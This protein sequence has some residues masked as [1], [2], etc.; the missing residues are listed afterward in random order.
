[1]LAIAVL[2]GSL[3]GC[4]QDGTGTNGRAR[5][6][7]AINAIHNHRGDDADIYRAMR[8]AED[9]ALSDPQSGYSE[10]LEA[11]M[12]STWRLRRDG[13]PPEVLAEVLELSELALA[14]DPDLAEAYIARARALLKA[15]R[16][17]EAD[18]ALT[19]VEAREPDHF[20]AR[21]QRAEWHARRGHYAEAEAMLRQ[22]AASAPT[23]TRRANALGAIGWVYERAARDVPEQADAHLQRARVAYEQWV[24]AMP[25]DIPALTYVAHFLQEELAAYKD[26]A[27][28]TRKLHEVG[29]DYEAG[30][31]L[32][33]ARYQGLHSNTSLTPA[34]AA[35]QAALI[36]RQTGISLAIA[37]TDANLGPRI[38]ARLTQ[39]RT[40]LDDA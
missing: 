12:L 16:L 27:R 15:G 37:S 33:A 31:L 10:A 26:S 21:F 1:M 32:A 14:R 8:A 40:K 7:D 3:V 39:L 35:A 24:D 34:E 17:D 25:G 4:G 18:Q 36:E 28:L 5:Y 9:L 11:E 38:K 20:S 22:F 23:P 30:L 2:A 6:L 19:E 13:T 29:A